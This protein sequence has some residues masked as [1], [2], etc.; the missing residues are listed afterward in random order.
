M[1]TQSKKRVYIPIPTT[2]PGSIKRRKETKELVDFLKHLKK[3][4]YFHLLLP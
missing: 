1:K 3:N 2:S 4:R